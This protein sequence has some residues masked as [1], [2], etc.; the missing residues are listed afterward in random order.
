MALAVNVPTNR[1]NA[2][3]VAKTSKFRAF[4]YPASCHGQGAFSM[5]GPFNQTQADPFSLG[6]VLF[7]F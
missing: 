2:S 7:Y 6:H 4:V 3:P 5:M 1:K